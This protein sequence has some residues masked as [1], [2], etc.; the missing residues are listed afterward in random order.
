MNLETYKLPVRFGNL[1]N[2]LLRVI[3]RNRW[4]II[5]KMDLS[6]IGYEREDWIKVA[7]DVFQRLALT[8]M[9][10]NFYVS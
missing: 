2:K 6:E 5:L 9:I 1:D 10:M 4:K 3:L 8:K 7:Q